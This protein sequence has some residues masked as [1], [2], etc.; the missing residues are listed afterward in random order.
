M[1][2]SLLEKCGLLLEKSGPLLEKS[3]LLLG[4]SGFLLENNGR[5]F[6][7]LA[8][9]PDAGSLPLLLMTMKLVCVVVF[10]AGLSGPIRCSPGSDIQ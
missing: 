2:N 10:L 6:G 7:S 8:P 4:K 3:C 1:L 5:F 9:S